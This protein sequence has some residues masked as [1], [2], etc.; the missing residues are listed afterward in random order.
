MEIENYTPPKRSF[1]PKIINHEVF[2]QQLKMKKEHLNNQ[3][4]Q[5]E[6][7][8]DEVP[9]KENGDTQ[10]TVSAKKA[11]ALLGQSYRPLK[12]SSKNDDI[13]SSI[14]NQEKERILE[15]MIRKHKEDEILRN[16]GIF[17]Q[18]ELTKQINKNIEKIKH[19]MEPFLNNLG[20]GSKELAN[21][22]FTHNLLSNACSKLV[23][24]NSEKITEMI[25]DDIMMELVDILNENEKN[26]NKQEKSE[27]KK[28]LIDDFVEALKD[29]QCDQD[30]ILNKRNEFVPIENRIR[31]IKV[32]DLIKNEQ[33]QYHRILELSEKIADKILQEKLEIDSLI[34]GKSLNDKKMV[35]RM[36]DASEILINQVFNEVFEEFDR[37]QDEFVERLYE[38]EFF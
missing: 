16:K 17:K 5:I 36:K 14:E 1:P 21:Y 11:K 28:E 24:V 29:L 35:N 31:E 4:N 27:E 37:A 23:C 8:I 18:T 2:E 26:E 12:V 7:D 9:T 34:N 6:N 3:N 10:K 33:K 32:D 22:P 19:E 38:Q 25:V 13:V 30:E 15:E 20:K